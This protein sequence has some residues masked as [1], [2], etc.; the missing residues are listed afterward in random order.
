LR[1]EC[2]SDWKDLPAEKALNE[3]IFPVGGRIQTLEWSVIECV[4]H[5]LRGMVV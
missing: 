2:S 1:E 3:R 4:A 5:S